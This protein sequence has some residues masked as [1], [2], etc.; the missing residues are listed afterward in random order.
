MHQNRPSKLHS[1]DVFHGLDDLGVVE[2]L[3]VGMSWIERGT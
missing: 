2:G 3:Y 1:L